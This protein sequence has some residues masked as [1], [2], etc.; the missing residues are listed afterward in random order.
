VADILNEPLLK[1][2]DHVW[3]AARIVNAALEN[4]TLGNVFR[5]VYQDYATGQGKVRWGDKS[6]YLDCLPAIHQLFPDAQYIHIV[7]D[8]RDVANSVMK[9]DWG[10]NDLIAAAVWWNDYVWLA[11]RIGAVLGPQKYMETRYEDL[12]TNTEAELRRVCAFLGEE[13]SAGMLE[14]YKDSAAKIPG[15]RKELHHNTNAPPMASRVYAWKRVMSPAENAV[16]L[17]YAQ[18][19]LDELNYETSANSVGRLRELG[20]MAIILGKRLLRRRVSA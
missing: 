20:E 4:P 9:L 14:Y 8:G 6:K 5:C 1:K 17:R 7:R 19:M 11:R 12:V 13:Y 15:D 3:D 10:P 18:R 2:W 16:F